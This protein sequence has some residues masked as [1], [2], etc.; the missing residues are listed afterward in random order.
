M[1]FS[2]ESHAC[3]T[4]KCQTTDEY[5]VYYVEDYKS[6]FVLHVYDLRCETRWLVLLV[7]LGLKIK[8]HLK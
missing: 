3:W 2:F 7:C 4:N 5:T 6:P 1:H 8:S